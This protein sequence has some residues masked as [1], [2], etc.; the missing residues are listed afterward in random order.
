MI[1]LWGFFLSS[2]LMRVQHSTQ[3]HCQICG[4][5]L[6]NQ[7]CRPSPAVRGNTSV[8]VV[9]EAWKW[10]QASFLIYDPSFSKVKVCFGNQTLRKSQ[11]SFKKVLRNHCSDWSEIA[12]LGVKPQLSPIKTAKSD[13]NDFK[14]CEFQ[15]YGVVIDFTLELCKESSN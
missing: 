9:A 13:Q 8:K 10:K 2:C 14:A 3:D 5:R 1:I 12:G 4:C 11:R 6:Q 15:P 7:S